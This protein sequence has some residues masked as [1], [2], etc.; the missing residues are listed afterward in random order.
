MASRIAYAALT[1][2][3][4]GFAWLAPA[5][6]RAC[7]CM[8]PPPPRDAADAA[9]AVFQGKVTALQVDQ[10]EGAYLAFH[11]YTLEVERVWKGDVV[12]TL[13]VRTADN[14]AACGRPFEV[15]ESYLVYAKDVEGQLSD[16]LCSRTS[17][18]ADASED[19]DALGPAIGEPDAPAAP[20]RPEPP[21]VEPDPD[22]SAGGDAPPPASPNARGC[23]VTDVPAAR[24][25]AGSL[26]LLVAWLGSRRRRRDR[27]PRIRR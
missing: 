17:K 8:R 12:D 4:A 6:A 16:N 5:P 9:T 10:P 14:S 27:D 25:T 20:A 15:G 24:G 1:L 26:F 7:S 21:P 19:L 2:G 13:T 3:L 22:A 23:A 11:V 18:L